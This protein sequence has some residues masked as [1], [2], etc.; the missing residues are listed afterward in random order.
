MLSSLRFRIVLKNKQSYAGNMPDSND[1][2]KQ[3]IKTNRRGR[4]DRPPLIVWDTAS[5]EY[6]RNHVVVTAFALLLLVVFAVS[7][8]RCYPPLAPAAP[9]AAH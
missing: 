1:N 2:L 7:F 5:Y 9:V 8:D 3:N 4:H 6:E